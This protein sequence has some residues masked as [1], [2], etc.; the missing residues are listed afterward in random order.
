MELLF[1][2]LRFAAGN[3]LSALRINWGLKTRRESFFPELRIIIKKKL[4]SLCTGPI[5]KEKEITF[6]TIHRL[7]LVYGTSIVHICV[8][9]GVYDQSAISL[10]AQ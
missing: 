10:A 3:F 9:S 1:C 5:I 4:P 8:P 7:I 2:L 6:L